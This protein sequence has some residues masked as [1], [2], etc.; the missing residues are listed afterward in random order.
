[1]D[2]ILFITILFCGATMWIAETQLRYN[3]PQLRPAWHGSR[4]LFDLFM[5]C[6]YLMGVAAYASAVAW[7]FVHL[8]WWYVPLA[9]VLTL[10]VSIPARLPFAPG[11]A[12]GRSAGAATAV[13]RALILFLPRLIALPLAVAI[14]VITKSELSHTGTVTGGLPA[15]TAICMLGVFTG[16]VMLYIRANKDSYLLQPW[17]H[18]AHPFFLLWTVFYS[19]GFG[20]FLSAIVWGFVH[21]PWWYVIVWLG[22][23]IFATPYALLFLW[24]WKF[25]Q[26]TDELFY[27]LVEV[28]PLVCTPLLGI[29]IWFL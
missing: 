22:I 5:T 10:L 4:S 20:G 1:M 13:L 11:F 28:I 12:H 23:A 16:Y 27:L 19:S 25:R 29:V 21:L 3:H 6:T 26:R 17:H 9:I 15:G 24:R 14:W 7:G 2:A 8:R 18:P